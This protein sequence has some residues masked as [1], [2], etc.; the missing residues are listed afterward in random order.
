MSRTS[1]KIL[2]S[3]SMCAA[4]GTPHCSCVSVS[5]FFP[6]LFLSGLFRLHSFS[7]NTLLLM[8]RLAKCFYMSPPVCLFVSNEHFFCSRI[9]SPHF[10]ILIRTYA[11]WFVRSFA[12]S[13][14]H[15]SFTLGAVVAAL[16][17]YLV[18]WSHCISGNVR[19]IHI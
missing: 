9:F 6:F 4:F 3:I 17:S 5:D 13:I 19:H 14:V 12:R 16:F 1:K 2:R 10:L 7:F 8:L 18:C 15:S 11:R